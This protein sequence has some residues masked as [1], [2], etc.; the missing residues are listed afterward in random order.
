MEEDTF[1]PLTLGGKLM[2][3]KE[4]RARKVFNQ[5]FSRVVHDTLKQNENIRL[6]KKD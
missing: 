3:K 6:A 4:I 2:K 5:I 1:F